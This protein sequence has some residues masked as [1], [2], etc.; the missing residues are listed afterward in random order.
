MINLKFQCSFCGIGIE[1]NETD[2]CDLNILINIDKNENKQ[3]NQFFYCHLNCF[4]EKLHLNHSL[5][6]KKRSEVLEK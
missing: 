6:L 1:E 2:P 3:F 5:N 4:K